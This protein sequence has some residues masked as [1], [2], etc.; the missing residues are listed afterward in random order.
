M[1]AEI[2]TTVSFNWLAMSLDRLPKV[3]NLDKVCSMNYKKQRSTIALGRNFKTPTTNRDHALFRPRTWRLC[4]VK[5]RAY[6]FIDVRPSI[7]RESAKTFHPLLSCLSFRLDFSEGPSFKLMPSS[8]NSCSTCSSAD[9]SPPSSSPP[10]SPSPL[11][12]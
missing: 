10:S 8:R 9:S 11:P 1:R 6:I 2:A 12:P 5:T 3:G 7:W 4:N